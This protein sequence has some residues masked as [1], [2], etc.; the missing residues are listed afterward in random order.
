MGMSMFGQRLGLSGLLVVLL[1]CAILL[2]RGTAAQQ[3]ASVGDIT[4][5]SID[6]ES[7]VVQGTVE[8]AAVDQELVVSYVGIDRAGNQTEAGAVR[9]TPPAGQTPFTGTVPFQFTLADLGTVDYVMIDVALSDFSDTSA[10]RV[11]VDCGTEPP[12]TLP[13]P[14]TS[15]EEVDAYIDQLIAVIIA[16]IQAVLADL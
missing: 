8:V 9:W 10:T 1:L 15:P 11:T 4:V 3:A 16:T 2:P 12:L 13:P 14:P 5:T 6:C 7:G